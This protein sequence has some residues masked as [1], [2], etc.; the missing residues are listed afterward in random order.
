MHGGQ[1]WQEGGDRDKDTDEGK[2][3]PKGVRATKVGGP[4]KDDDPEESEPDPSEPEEPEDPEP[5]DS[6]LGAGGAANGGERMPRS[7][8][9]DE[10]NILGFPL[11]SQ[12]RAWR[13]HAIKAVI[14]AAGR[15]GDTAFPWIGKC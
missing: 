9:A 4:K 11:G 14:S 8:E 3:P 5:E 10:V 6:G 2:D 1:R 13:A 7:R 12:W 15:Q